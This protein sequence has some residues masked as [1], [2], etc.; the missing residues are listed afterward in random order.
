MHLI[1][2]T[3]DLKPDIVELHTIQSGEKSISI[4]ITIVQGK[5]FAYENKCPHT[6]LALTTAS[7][8]INS[9][10][11]QYIQCSSH[12]AQFRKD[13]GYCVYGPCKGQSLIKLNTGI[14]NGNIYY[15]GDFP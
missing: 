11:K 6:W 9:G 8:D 13:N 14:E 15:Y 5:V 4:V 12:F 2:K 1:C 10:C 3:S 7:N